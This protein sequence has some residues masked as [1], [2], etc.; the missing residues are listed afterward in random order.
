MENEIRFFGIELGG[1][2]EATFKRNFQLTE[3][4][5]GNYTVY[6]DKIN[7]RITGVVS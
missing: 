5:A 3:G 6:T 2:W 7:S 1:I 4:T